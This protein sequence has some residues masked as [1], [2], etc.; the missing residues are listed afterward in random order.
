MTVTISS[1]GVPT[2]TGDDRADV[3][4]VKAEAAQ[5]TITPDATTDIGFGAGGARR[6]ESY[7][8]LE[9]NK[10]GHDKPSGPVSGVES[11]I[12]HSVS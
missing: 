12:D 10:N 3:A 7:A 5:V 6:N 2:L 8:R 9:Q 11:E 4:S 1:A